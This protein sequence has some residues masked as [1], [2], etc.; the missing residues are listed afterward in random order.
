M[1]ALASVQIFLFPAWAG[2]ILNG[3]KFEELVATIP[4]MG[5]GDPNVFRFQLHDRFYSPHGRG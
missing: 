5:G 2:V 4:R 3:R 1:G